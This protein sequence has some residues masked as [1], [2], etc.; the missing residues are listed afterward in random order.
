MIWML[1][2]FSLTSQSYELNFPLSFADFLS[3]LYLKPTKSRI[4]L[5]KELELREQNF[6]GSVNE[7]NL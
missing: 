7:L 2:I 1:H 5:S 6:N 4:P 3:A